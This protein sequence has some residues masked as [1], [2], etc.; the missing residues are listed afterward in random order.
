MLKFLNNR[1]ILEDL[2]ILMLG[3]LLVFLKLTNQ[4]NFYIRKD[5]F[6]F[7]FLMGIVLVIAGIIRVIVDLSSEA[8]KNINHHSHCSCHDCG[9]DCH[10]HK[11]S[12]SF[13]LVIICLIAL[14]ALGGFVIPRK[15]LSA[16]TAVRRTGSNT[17]VSG[18][19]PRQKSG[20]ST[21]IKNINTDKY[22]IADWIRSFTL[23]P[24]PSDYLNKIV[25]IKGFIESNDADSFRVTR[26]VITCC[27]VDATPVS[28]IVDEPIGNFQVNEWVYINGKFKVRVK[29]GKREI[30]INPDKIEKI[31]IPDD[32]YL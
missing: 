9:D 15:P 17:F 30:I 28:L 10:E 32:P 16:V 20:E 27:V 26:F 23:N 6:L 12:S 18:S 11:H 25:D 8:H 19:G 13:S 29:N 7:T 4:L 22:T 21:L 3:A 24:E 14:V 2:L 31:N 1:N 5:Y